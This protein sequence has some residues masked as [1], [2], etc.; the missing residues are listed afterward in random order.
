MRWRELV[1]PL[2]LN[3]AGSLIAVAVV[4]VMVLTAGVLTGV[5]VSEGVAALFGLLLIAAGAVVVGRR[6]N[7]A[8]LMDTTQLRNEL[9]EELDPAERAVVMRFWQN[10]AGSGVQTH[11]QAET[12]LKN[13]FERWALRRQREA[14]EAREGG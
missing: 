2:A 10:P 7:E 11:E 3:V 12:M 5:S 8:I 1:G 4:F 14:M 13:A 6:A 9:L